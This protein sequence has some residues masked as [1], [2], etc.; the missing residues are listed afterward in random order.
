MISG[1]SNVFHE[2]KGMIS[3]TST[4]GWLSKYREALICKASRPA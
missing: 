2:K 1:R 4:R 3:Q